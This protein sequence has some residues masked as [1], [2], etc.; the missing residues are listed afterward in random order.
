MQISK[1]RERKTMTNM[2]IFEKQQQ[3]QKRARKERLFPIPVR[4]KLWKGIFD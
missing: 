1:R 3:K 2:A 4:I